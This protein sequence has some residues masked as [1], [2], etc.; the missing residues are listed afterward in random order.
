M[1]P[2]ET[3]VLDNFLTQLVQ[4]RVGAKDPQAEAMIA[5]A[6]A[7]QPD[8]AYLLVQRALLLDQALASAKAQISSLQNELQ[9]VRSSNNAGSSFFD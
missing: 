1:T 8:A 2:Q 6:L 5:T 7:K 3:Q 4:A 9:A